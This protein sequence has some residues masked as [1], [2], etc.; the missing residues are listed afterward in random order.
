MG[1]TTPGSGLQTPASFGTSTENVPIIFDRVRIRTINW[2]Y[3]NDTLNVVFDYGREDPLNPGTSE[4]FTKP[5][6]HPLVDV[7][8]AD[9]VNLNGLPFNRL[10]GTHYTTFKA[11]LGTATETTQEN[12]EDEIF[13]AFINSGYFPGGVEI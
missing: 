5:Q 11:S 7:A 12:L 2:D 8:V 13:L 1:D 6:A 10:V 3:I 4:W 9:T